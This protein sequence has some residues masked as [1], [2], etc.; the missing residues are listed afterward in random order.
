MQDEPF[1]DRPP[2]ELVAARLR[3]LRRTALVLTSTPDVIA[4]VEDELH[5]V[6]VDHDELL[7]IAAKQV[8][9][10]IEGYTHDGTGLP[11]DVR[12]QLERAVTDAGWQL[13]G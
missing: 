10:G 1:A 6:A 11:A 3:E 4:G 2:I 8:G 12:R 5:R 9:L 7:V 13:D